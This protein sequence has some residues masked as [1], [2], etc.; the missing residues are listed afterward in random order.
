MTAAKTKTL[1]SSGHQE[2]HQETRRRLVEPHEHPDLQLPA[3]PPRFLSLCVLSLFIAPPLTPQT[4][5]PSLPA[6]PC[7]HRLLAPPTHFTPVHA[8]R[9]IIIYTFKV[10]RAQWL[11]DCVDKHRNWLVFANPS[12]RLLGHSLKNSGNSFAV[13]VKRREKKPLQAAASRCI[14]YLH[15][16]AK[17]HLFAHT[18]A[19][20]SQ[21]FNTSVRNMIITI[22]LKKIKKC[23]SPSIEVKLRL[24]RDAGFLF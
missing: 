19:F 11:Q 8:R 7:Y 6:V 10:K 3:L 4:A 23:L 18:S 1:K 22:I 15:N 9:L 5:R 20:L 13:T 2:H 21:R 24:L 12:S 16:V 14:S 17:P